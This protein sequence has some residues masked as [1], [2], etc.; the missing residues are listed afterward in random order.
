MLCFDTIIVLLI[1]ISFSVMEWIYII[2]RYTAG[3]LQTKRN[4][5]LYSYAEI[6]TF[7]PKWYRCFF[8]HW[9]EKAACYLPASVSVISFLFLF[10]V[11]SLFLFS[12]PFPI[13]NPFSPRYRVRCSNSFISKFVPLIAKPLLQLREQSKMQDFEI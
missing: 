7:V 9:C 5:S 11:S 3:Q 13:R 2:Y 6:K 10:K 1:I 8:L 4:I 12:F